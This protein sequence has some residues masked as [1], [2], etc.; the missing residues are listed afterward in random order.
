MAFR[1]GT[2]L[3]G[4]F[5]IE[6]NLAAVPELERKEL[7]SWVALYKEVRELLHTGEVVRAQQHD[8]SFAV[9]GAGW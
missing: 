1:A 6:W 8:P 5:G 7:A 2:A 4:S 3:F 9:H